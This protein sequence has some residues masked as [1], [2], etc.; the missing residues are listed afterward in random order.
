[1]TKLETA[2]KSAGHWDVIYDLYRT[3]QLADDLL[4]HYEDYPASPGEFAAWQSRRDDLM[5]RVYERTGAD[6]KY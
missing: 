3:K 2:V 4:A 6:P 1:L 5:D